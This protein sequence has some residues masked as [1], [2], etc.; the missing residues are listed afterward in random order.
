MGL[1]RVQIYTSSHQAML[2]Q[3]QRYYLSSLT[4][5]CISTS[6]GVCSLCCPKEAGVQRLLYSWN[7][8]YIQAIQIGKHKQ[9]TNLNL[10]ILSKYNESNMS[11]LVVLGPPWAVSTYMCIH[12]Y[13]Y[14][15]MYVCAR[16]CGQMCCVWPQMF[17]CL[18]LYMCVCF[19]SGECVDITV[20]CVLT[21]S[22]TC[23]HV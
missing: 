21:C 12:S 6:S 4:S 9:N 14:M 17:Q 5:H 7:T 3:A 1:I 20:E 22:G 11:A 15:N 10:K 13:V 23:V 19:C 18:Y 8:S 2:L 16:V